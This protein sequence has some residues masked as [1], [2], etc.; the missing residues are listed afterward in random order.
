MFESYTANGIA[1]EKLVA[2]NKP[3]GFTIFVDHYASRCQTEDLEASEKAKEPVDVKEIAG[4]GGIKKPKQ[5]FK[6][7]SETFVQ[8]SLKSMS[9]IKTKIS[10]K[11][12][13]TTKNK[14]T[15]KNTTKLNSKMLS[16]QMPYPYLYMPQNMNY[17]YTN[18][19]P[20]VPY[21]PNQMPN[22]PNQMQSNN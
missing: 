21:M 1:S 16:K 19:V 7:N 4:G 5:V 13:N 10:T 20:N 9:K 22:M 17:Q 6:L 14:L 3:K 15:L 8:L 12:M 18:Q 2:R 11:A